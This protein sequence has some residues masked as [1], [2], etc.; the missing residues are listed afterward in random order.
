MKKRK[1]N[2]IIEKAIREWFQKTNKKL[3]WYK[4]E[5]TIDE[6][7]FLSSHIKWL[8][9]EMDIFYGKEI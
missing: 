7:M 5:M 3:G 4:K 2:P 1:D 9:E 8:R 6:V